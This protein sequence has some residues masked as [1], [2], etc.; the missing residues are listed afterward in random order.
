MVE[1]EHQRSR[2]ATSDSPLA[3]A[4]CYRFVLTQV[5]ENL[6]VLDAPPLTKAELARIRTIG[7]HVYGRQ[8]RA[9]SGTEA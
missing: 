2:G 9:E 7:D 3:A 8:S 4:D 1:A 5:R 6:R